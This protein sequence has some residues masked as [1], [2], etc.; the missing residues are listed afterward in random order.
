MKRIA[1]LV[2]ATFAALVLAVT[3]SAA[4]SV[5][6]ISI[7]EP[8]P[9]HYGDTINVTYETKV[10]GPWV[11]LTCYANSTTVGPVAPGDLIVQEYRFVTGPL[12]LYEAG[13]FK[14]GLWNGGGADC[15]VSLDRFYGNG[16]HIVLASVSITVLP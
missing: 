13:E 1:S 6:S 8:G 2:A 15:I 5:S 3:V 12:P 11:G 16:K 14:L 4:P 10:S 7:V 9:Y